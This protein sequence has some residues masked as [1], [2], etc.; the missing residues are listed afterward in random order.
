MAITTITYRQISSTS[1]STPI[2]ETDGGSTT[3]F[4]R[5]VIGT[6]RIIKNGATLNFTTS[7]PS[8]VDKLN[9][10][11]HAGDT[12]T[13]SKD[14]KWGVFRTG[15]WYDWSYTDRYQILR[16]MYRRGSTHRLA[17]ST[18]I[19]SRKPCSLLPSMSSEQPRG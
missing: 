1:I 12:A 11:R 3:K 15:F 17:T 19:S 6:S 2:S 4:I 5:P 18:N 14:S 8:G 7:K 16:P 13:L 9:G 10:Y